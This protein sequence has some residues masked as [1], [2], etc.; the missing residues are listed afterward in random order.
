M[1]RL[2]S[3]HSSMSNCGEPMTTVNELTTRTL[4]NWCPACGNYNIVFA[5][6]NALT[7]LNIPRENTVLVSGIGCGS[8]TPHFLDTYGFESLHGRGLPVATGIKLANPKLTVIVTAG[9][10]DTYGIGGNHFVHSMRRNLDITLIVQDNCVYGLTKGQYSPTS[11][12]GMKTPSSPNGAI[13]EPLNPIAM[14]VVAGATYISR[15]FAYE[16]QHLTSLI[17][18]A[19]A[20]K[21]FSL[22][23]VLQPC[24]TYNKFQNLQWYKDNIY[25]LEDVGHDSSDIAAA[26]ARAG[27]WG[28]KQVPIGLFYKDERPTYDEQATD[29]SVAEDDISKINIRSLLDKAR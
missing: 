11:R 10:G 15:G 8:K 5:I 4:P 16:I 13:E 26:F 18:G 23:D 22:V 17:K 20:H 14:G 19:I 12:K 3:I 6:K 9:D 7:Q 25:K 21:G 1:E 27:E 28:E 24:S 29:H 2:I